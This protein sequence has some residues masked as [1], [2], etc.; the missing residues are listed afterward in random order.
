M[1]YIVIILFVSFAADAQ[2]SFFLPSKNIYVYNKGKDTIYLKRIDAGRLFFSNRMKVVDSVQIDG[3]GSKE[4][5]FYRE[6]SGG[7][8]DHGGTF[9]IMESKTAGKFE[10]W[11]PD[12]KTL[13]FEAVSSWSHSYDGFDIRQH[14]R[15]QK[16]EIRYRYDFAIDRSGVISI[17][18]FCGSK[19]AKPDNVVGTYQFINGKYTKT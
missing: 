10:I 8:S 19:D 4:L 1:K 5:V 11:D 18:N 17:D 6:V 2:K 16:F 12:T 9:D 15:N 13:L 14:P 7:R 3:K